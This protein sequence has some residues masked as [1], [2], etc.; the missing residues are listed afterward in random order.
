MS[1][2]LNQRCHMLHLLVCHTTYAALYSNR[3]YNQEQHLHS[4]QRRDWHHSNHGQIA[5]STWHQSN[6]HT[7]PVPL[8]LVASG[9][10]WHRVMRISQ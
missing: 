10:G 2:V 7:V 9:E 8:Q 3:I 5:S 6:L 4:C 1:H